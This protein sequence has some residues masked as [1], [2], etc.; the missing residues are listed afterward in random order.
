[1]TLNIEEDP[2]EA[3]AIRYVSEILP[4]VSLGELMRVCCALKTKFCSR[5]FITKA[6]H[7][8]IQARGSVTPQMSWN[9]FAP[10][11]LRSWCEFIISAASAFKYGARARVGEADLPPITVSYHHPNYPSFA[12]GLVH[13]CAGVCLT[14]KKSFWMSQMPTVEFCN[15]PSI[16]KLLQLLEQQK[17]LLCMIDYSYPG[18]RSIEVNFLG[19]PCRIPSGLIEIAHRKR[20]EVGFFKPSGNSVGELQVFDPRSYVGYQSMTQDIVDAMS[21]SILSKPEGWL[22]WPNLN[23][24]CDRELWPV[25]N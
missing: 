4:D 1:L 8:Y 18:S 5:E 12:A 14:H 22:L 16:R 20:L 13:A 15:T 7:C 11:Y 23:H 19:L 10:K 3:F 2:S 24:I 21:A 17:P 25:A 9:E 6:W